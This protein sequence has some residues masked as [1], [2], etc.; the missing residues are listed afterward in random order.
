MTDS[1]SKKQFTLEITLHIILT[2]LTL[3]I[4]FKFLPTTTPFFQ[5]I[6]LVIVLSIVIIDCVFLIT[7]RMQFLIITRRLLIYLF[8]IS[9][10]IIATFYLTKLLVLTNMFGFEKLLQLHESTAIWIYFAICFAQP[11]IL[12]FPEM[13][14]VAGASSVFGSLTAIYV[15]FIGTLSGIVVMYFVARIGGRRIVSRI[16]KEEQLTKYQNYVQKNEMLFLVIMFIIPVLPDEII[17]IG[18]GLSGVRFKRFLPIATISKLFTTTTFAYSAILVK[19][20]SLTNTEL[21]VY[22]S[23]FAGVAFLFMAFVKKKRTSQKEAPY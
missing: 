9:M 14:T 1:L 8:V 15:G 4:L 16:V 5:W 21:M 18:A 11:I 13:I 10:L 23:I 12:P 2:T 3:V 6:G 20:F 7:M 19:E 22:S 17:C